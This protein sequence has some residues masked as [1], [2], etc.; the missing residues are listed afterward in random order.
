MHQDGS[1][2]MLTRVLIKQEVALLGIGKVA[3]PVGISKPNPYDNLLLCFEFDI[4]NSRYVKFEGCVKLLANMYRKPVRGISE[5]RLVGIRR[6][7]LQRIW[8]LMPK[9]LHTQF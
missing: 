6:S 5:S 1:V 3:S 7:L 8:R 2:N 4:S 9:T